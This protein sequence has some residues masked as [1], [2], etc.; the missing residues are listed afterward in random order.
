MPD[1]RSEV[2]IIGGGIAGIATALDLLDGGGSVEVRP[3]MEFQE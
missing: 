2:L 3:V 1:C